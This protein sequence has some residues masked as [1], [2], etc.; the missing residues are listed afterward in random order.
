MYS[1][2]H[3]QDKS[4]QETY[5]LHVTNL[6]ATHEEHAHTVQHKQL[7]ISCKPCKENESHKAK[8][9]TEHTITLSC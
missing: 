3:L 7:T 6:R 1:T 2:A 5:K 8:H 9:Y 4:T